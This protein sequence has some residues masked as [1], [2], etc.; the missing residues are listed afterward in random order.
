M[1]NTRTKTKRNVKKITQ[2]IIIAFFLMVIFQAFLG[3]AYVTGESMQPTYE[4]GDIILFKKWA[5]PRK[6]DIVTAYIDE[7]DAVVIKRVFATEGD[8]LKF[9]QNAV[10]INGEYMEI[11][12]TEVTEITVPANHYFLIGD[13]GA[14]SQDSRNFG[15]VGKSSI[16]G[17]VIRKIL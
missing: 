14:Y 7:I 2:A 8:H 4:N 17:I 3:I 9:A 6:G 15:C 12:N 1:V 10:Y 16:Q 11:K 5:A 13:N